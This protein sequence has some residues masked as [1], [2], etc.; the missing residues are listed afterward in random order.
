MKQIMA[1]VHGLVQGVSFRYYTQQEA[2]R[3]GVTGWVGN[4][5]DGSVQVLAEGDDDQ[6]Y[7]FVQ[8]LHHGPPAAKVKRVE[9]KWGE[10]SGEHRHF[11]VRYL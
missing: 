4:L 5:A 1:V 2:R 11:D 3:L 6:L 9:V 8:W 7:Q 10:A